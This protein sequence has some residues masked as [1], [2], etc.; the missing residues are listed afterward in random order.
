MAGHT[1][2]E[3]EIRSIMDT[4]STPQ[5]KFMGKKGEFAA[6]AIVDKRNKNLK[7]NFKGDKT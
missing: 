7:F 4:G 3:G 2:S 6:S 5:I 1:F